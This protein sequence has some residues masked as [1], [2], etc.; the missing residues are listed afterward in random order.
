MAR[1][2]GIIVNP[3][4][5]M[6]GRVGLKG[7]DGAETLLRARALG[8]EPIAAA[9]CLRALRRLI[10][11][12]PCQILAPP[13]AMG[14]AVAA[15]AGLAPTAIDL[16]TQDA[17]NAEDTRLA[18]TRMAAAGVDLIL[19]AG[20]DGTARDV[21]AGVGLSVPILGVPTGV[22]MQSAV[23]GTSPEAA[24]SIAARFL[25]DGPG[26]IRL[27]EAEVMDLD[28]AA[29]RQG[30]VVAR[31]FG[32][33]MVPDDGHSMQSAKAPSLPDDD[34]ALDALARRVAREWP[35]DRLLILGCGTTTRRLKRALGFEGTLLGVDAILG[36]Y[37]VALDVSEATLLHLLERTPRAAIA[38]SPTGG[39]GFL[40]GRGN[41][42]IS[43]EAI[44][45]VGRDGIMV[46]AGARK[47]L[48]LRPTVLHVD[49]GD[50]AVDAMLAGH[51]A[52]HTAPGRQ[53][54]MKLVT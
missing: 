29:L 51:I 53:M 26:R 17:T 44:R 41:Q 54:I 1:R 16:P 49:T 42:Q 18:A 40:F 7:T 50:I 23:F 6:G 5:G 31:L 22:K 11:E 27:R 52:V 19:F 39:Q 28:E 45:R 8:A 14:G 15:D 25:R 35:E 9:R 13:G 33:A 30:Q 48:G 38:V 24:G 2:L 37:P 43:P 36:G 47:L 46:L 4:A 21:L 34:D 3:I 20:G 12:A 32:T 10:A